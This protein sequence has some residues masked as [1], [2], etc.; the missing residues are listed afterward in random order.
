MISMTAV[1]TGAVLVFGALAGCRQPDA[2]MA[3]EF[4][5]ETLAFSPISATQ[6]GY[7]I[8]N[9]Q[10]LDEMLDDLSEPALSRQRD[11]YERFRTRLRAVDRS[12]A[13]AEEKADLDVMQKQ[14]EL[15]LLELNTIQNCRHNPAT[16]VE[17]IGNAVYV[18]YALDYAPKP[19]R[20]QHITARLRK[21]PD[22]LKQA[23]ANLVSAPDVWI[24]VA[25]EEDEG[26]IALIDETLRRECPSEVKQEFDSAAKIA[27]DEL[28]AFNTYLKNELS[29][30]TID[31]RLGGSNYAQKFRYA[32]GTDRTPADVLN[33]AESQLKSVRERMTQI[34]AP[35]TVER[36]LDRIAKKHATPDT[37]FDEGRADLAEATTFVR[38]HH[39]VPLPA[40]G[41]LQVI[42]TP[43]FMRGVYAVG[44][45]SPAPALE[46]KLGAY[47]WITPVPKDWPASRIESKLREYNFYG[48][49]IL[50]VHEA[51]PG[52]W[53]QAEYA[54]RVSPEDRRAL[55]AVYGSVPYVEGWAVYATEYM[56]SDGYYKDDPGMQLT[57]YK[58][59]LRVISNTIL[60]IRL[61]T[62]NM[63]EAQAIELMISDTY[64]EKEEAV[65]KY[66]RAQL[67][68]CQLPAYF[69][70]WSDWRRLREDAQKAGGTGWNESRFHEAVL[71][72][73]AVGLDSLRALI[74]KQ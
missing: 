63:T 1:R 49:K 10:R 51:M 73:G 8:H 36:A 33:E 5:Y 31:W 22:F 64:Q 13:G 20:F 11:F 35:E 4:V 28:K 50:T 14:T 66:Q 48:L 61:Q 54:A 9:G 58:Q 6:A 72:P 12:G 17:L 60:D 71:E 7:H 21:I 39:F 56:I 42:P 26:N 15:A 30:H 40:G 47:Y 55:R 59:L 44:G 24:R 46:P 32:L 16:Y 19:T 41:N 45:F 29:Q 25:T 18:P 57:W 67:S 23:R 27:L 65:A 74:L 70:G 38:D 53:L 3:S 62:M 34:A 2:H 69:I 43:E 68:S 37:Y 52:H